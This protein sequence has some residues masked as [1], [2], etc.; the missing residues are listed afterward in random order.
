[1]TSNGDLPD[2]GAAQ[3]GPPHLGGGCRGV[4]CRSPTVV[5]GRVSGLRNIV[6]HDEGAA[7]LCSQQQNCRSVSGELTT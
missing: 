1:M 6:K 5:R 3:C 2:I 7:V 4:H